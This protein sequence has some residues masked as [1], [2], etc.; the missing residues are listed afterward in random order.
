MSDEDRAF[1][2]RA[3]DRLPPMEQYEARYDAVV[4]DMPEGGDDD[5]EREAD[6]EAVLGTLINLMQ[7]A[8]RDRSFDSR[9]MLL[10]YAI[11]GM[12][13]WATDKFD[14]RLDAMP[15][16]ERISTLLKAMDDLD[17]D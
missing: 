12:S 2:E 6:R 15:M 13:A 17:D 5:P 9:V 14:A 7:A 4:A 3:L 11:E 16:E 1:F 10:S 8:D